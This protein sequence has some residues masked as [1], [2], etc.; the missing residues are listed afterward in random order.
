MS[1]NVTV[2]SSTSE[3][4]GEEDIP[5]L[6]EGLEYAVNREVPN[7]ESIANTPRVPVTILTGYLGAGKTTLLNYILT[8]QHNKRIAV[9]LNEFGEGSTMEKS[10]NVGQGG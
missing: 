5:M 2:M 3:M 7:L 8:Q 4:T 10:L 9:I 1:A 6:V